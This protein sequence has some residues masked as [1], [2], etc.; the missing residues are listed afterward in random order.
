MH[1]DKTDTHDTRHKHKLNHESH[2]K[3]QTNR[4][5]ADTQDTIRT[6]S[7]TSMHRGI[8]ATRRQDR[9]KKTPTDTIMHMGQQQT[10]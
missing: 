3:A 6:T 10:T 2:M 9:H 8:Q 4:Q 7:D 5:Q 1:R